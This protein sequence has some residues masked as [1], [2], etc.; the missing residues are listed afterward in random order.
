MARNAL[1]VIGNGLPSVINESYDTYYARML[2]SEGTHLHDDY[3]LDYQD[4][5]EQIS[6]PVELNQLETHRSSYPVP[7]LDSKLVGFTTLA[8]HIDVTQ[9]MPSYPHP[10][11]VKKN[12]PAARGF[13]GCVG[14]ITLGTNPMI[15]GGS[16]STESIGIFDPGYA[17][18]EIVRQKIVS[19]A[20]RRGEYT[21]LDG[22][23][24]AFAVFRVDPTAPHPLEDI[25]PSYKNKGDFRLVDVITSADAFPQNSYIHWERP[26]RTDGEI[27]GFEGEA[28][29]LSNMTR[30]MEATLRRDMAGVLNGYEAVTDGVMRGMHSQLMHD[31][32]SMKNDKLSAHPGVALKIKEM[33]GE[34]ANYSDS[35]M[36]WFSP[37]RGWESML[38]IRRHLEQGGSA[39]DVKG[40]QDEI[41]SELLQSIAAGRKAAELQ[42]ETH[43]L[44]NHFGRP[45]ADPVRWQIRGVDGL[46]R[47]GARWLGT[48]PDDSRAAEAGRREAKFYR[49]I[50][51]K[52]QLIIK[53]KGN[54]SLERMQDMH[55]GAPQTIQGVFCYDE[56][57]LGASYPVI[58]PQGIFP[59]DINLGPYDKRADNAG[60]DGIVG[61]FDS[62]GVNI[63]QAQ[64]Y[65]VVNLLRASGKILTALHD[66]GV[67]SDGKSELPENPTLSEILTGRNPAPDLELVAFDAL[68]KARHLMTVPEGKVAAVQMNEDHTQV[69][70]ELRPIST[71]FN[72]AKSDPDR[73]NSVQRRYKGQIANIYDTPSTPDRDGLKTVAEVGMLGR[74]VRAWSEK[75]EDGGPTFMV[76]KSETI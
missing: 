49:E 61:I 37:V 5:I 69:D 57:V 10:L 4:V 56:N 38:R 34:I 72:A 8:R 54:N 53:V 70:L 71:F 27:T 47:K 50:V 20:Y 33:I 68:K 9:H 31:G 63:K 32:Y 18:G 42:A 52:S 55:S 46:D 28:D 7:G 23:T 21:P 6:K 13:N 12:A 76:M 29:L 36:N 26:A 67:F 25:D 2:S 58:L 1:A 3:K 30:E 74:A 45:F 73:R 16:T 51:K 39:K 22:M 62:N 35:I 41:R 48:L 14:D 65:L 44:A 15:G 75:P 59:E 17:N 60:M 19:A 66:M 64:R 43:A 40:Y 24:Y 11:V